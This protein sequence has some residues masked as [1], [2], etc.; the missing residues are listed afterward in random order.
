MEVAD[1]HPAALVTEVFPNYFSTWPRQLVIGAGMVAVR[2][3]VFLSSGGFSA[4]AIN[5]EDHDLSLRL[6]LSQGFVQ[7]VAPL[8]MGWRLHGGGV[9]RELQKSA[10]GCDVLIATERAGGY[11]APRRGSAFG[12]T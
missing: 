7:V 1:E 11:P 9:T 5:L 3:D 2:R 8:T 10:S 4:A 6:G 12:T